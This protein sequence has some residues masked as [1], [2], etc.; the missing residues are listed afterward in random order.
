MSRMSLAEHGQLSSHD[1]SEEQKGALNLGLMRR[2]HEC[3]SRSYRWRD[4]SIDS[5]DLRLTDGVGITSIS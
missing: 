4:Q 1:S 5:E 3:F 2:R